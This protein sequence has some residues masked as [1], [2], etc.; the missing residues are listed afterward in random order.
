MIENSITMN[1]NVISEVCYHIDYTISQVIST[2]Y[3][4]NDNLFK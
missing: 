3:K 4:M 1:K 2:L